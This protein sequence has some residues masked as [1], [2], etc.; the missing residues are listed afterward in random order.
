LKTTDPDTR[1][2]L[3]LATHN[4][5]KGREIAQ[6]LSDLPITVR[7]LWEWPAHRAIDETGR[8]LEENARLK[9]E[10]ACA[11]TGSWALADDTGLLVN[12]LGG[13]PGVW[14]ARYSGPEATYASNR[15]K[16][17]DD[18]KSVPAGERGARFETVIAIARPGEETLTVAGRVEG[19]IL[20]IEKGAGGF[21]YDAVFYHPPSRRSF[22]ELSLEEKNAISHRGR[23]VNLARSLIVKLLNTSREGCAGR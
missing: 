15:Q 23:A 1:P 5:D 14:S 13:A 16:L 4:R 22:A 3:V 18:M 21:G 8:T 10:E 20:T 12:T 9:A 7:G 6:L 2:E 17:L 11:Y 19:E